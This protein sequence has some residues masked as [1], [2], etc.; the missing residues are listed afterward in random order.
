MAIED[1]SQLLVVVQ[2]QLVYWT[3]IIKVGDSVEIVGVGNTQTTTI[4]E[5]KCS[6]KL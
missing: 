4:T 1:V 3:W 5:L 6:K 2:L